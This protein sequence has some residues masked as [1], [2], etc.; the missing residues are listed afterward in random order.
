MRI[1][2][3]SIV[4]RDMIESDIEDYVRWFT[5]ETAWADF[6]SPGES[7]QGDAGTERQRWTAYFDSVRG[8][9]EHVLRWKF[10][11]E[12][13]GRHIGWVSSYMIDE[14]FDWIAADDVREGQLVRRAVGID[15]CEPDVWGR[16]LGTRALAAFLR[17]YFDR[18]AEEICTQTWS[19]NARMIRCAEKLG[20]HECDRCAG[21]IAMDGQAFDGLTFI[22]RKGG[23]L[24]PVS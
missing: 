9:P 17:Y 2:T 3:D 8:L 1:L 24:C 5:T 19:G 7:I 4:L 13:G 15:V 21:E 11:I 14:H 23:F 22:V 20:F 12:A 16:G 6:D 10:E 18:G